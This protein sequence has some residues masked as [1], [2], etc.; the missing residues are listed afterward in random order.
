MSARDLVERCWDGVT[1]RQGCA[2]PAAAAVLGD[3]VQTY[4]EP[5]RHYHTLGH[6]GA[7]L[8][9][10]DRHGRGAA[11]PDALRL[12]ILFHDVVYDPTR[13]DNEQAS[14]AVATERLTRLGFPAALVA[15][16]A[17]CIIA[18]RHDR[19][20]EAMGDADLALLLDLDLSIL[21][22]APGDYRAYAGAVRREYA[23]VPEHLYRPGRRRILEGFLARERIYLTEPLRALWEEPA[24]ANLGAERAAL[25]EVL[26]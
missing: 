2:G 23:F 26:T 8:A 9:L 12:A 1:L 17:H 24:R 20:A 22:A 11:D 6:I 15:K 3:L 13:H 7:L 16:V 19:P 25:A 14:A 21:A 4:G 5:H 10:L 18:T